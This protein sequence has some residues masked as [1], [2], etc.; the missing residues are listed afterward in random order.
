MNENQQ[1]WT[2]AGREQENA[3]FAAYVAKGYDVED[4]R[5]L[6]AANARP[7]DVHVAYGTALFWIL[8]GLT[9]LGILIIVGGALLQLFVP[10]DTYY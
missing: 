10:S 7:A 1:Q 2:R 9:L 4:A 8:G 6:A 3:L 5:Q